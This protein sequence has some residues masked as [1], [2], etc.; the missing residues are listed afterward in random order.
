VSFNS[1]LSRTLAFIRRAALDQDS[2]RGIEPELQRR[3]SI[4]VDQYHSGKLVARID[5]DPGAGL[6]AVA[7]QKLEKLGPLVRD[8]VDAKRHAYRAG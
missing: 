8:T 4:R 5:T 2:R 1:V 7:L 3:R 6:Q